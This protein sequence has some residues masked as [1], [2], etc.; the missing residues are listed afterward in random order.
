MND[1]QFDIVSREIMFTG[2]GSNS[3]FTLTQ[4][5]SVQNGGSLMLSRAANIYLPIFGIGIEDFINSNMTTG[6]AELGRWKQQVQ[7]DGGKGNYV[8]SPNINDIDFNLLVEY[9][10]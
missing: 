3:D 2:Q 8:G 4:N 6:A 5:P 10:E 7:Q 9:T 1:I